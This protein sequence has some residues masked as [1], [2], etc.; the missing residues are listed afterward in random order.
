MK[1]VSSR[2]K[3]I[4]VVIIAAIITG[5]IAFDDENFQIAKN[6]DIYHTL[7][8]ELNLYYVDETDPGDLVKKSIDEMLQS[9]DPYTVYI[10]ESKMEDYR[11]MTTGQYGGIGALIRTS[12]DFVI[13]SEPYEGFPAFKAGLKAG[14]KIV[15]IDGKS[16][17]GK[18]SQDISKLLKGE[19][20][21]EINLSIERI[22]K[23]K[24]IELKVVREKIQ[25][26]SVPYSGMID[27]NIGYIRLSSFTEKCSKEVKKAFQLLKKDNDLKGL[28]FDLRGNPGGLLM[29]AVAISNLFVPKGTEVVSTK[30]KVKQWN[31][32]YKATDDA[33]D[34]EIPIAVLVNSGSASAS[35]IV[36]GVIQDLDRGV[37]MG[38]RT[39]GKGLVQ[40]TRDLSYNSKLKIT[41]AKYYIPSGRCIQALDYTHRNEDGSVGRIPDSLVSEFNTKGG[42][43]VYDGGGVMPDIKVE[44]Q[45]LSKISVSLY[46]KNLV[47]DYATQFQYANDSILPTG[48]FELNDEMYNDFVAFLIDKE[49]DYTLESEKILDD[50]ETAIKKDK[51]SDR[52]SGEIEDLRSKL[53]HDKDKDLQLFNSE[54]RDLLREEIISR[55]YY[56]RG[57]A[58][59]MIME[60]PLVDSALVVLKNKERYNSILEVEM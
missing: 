11:F 15:E 4:T 60:D 58:K 1:K 36:S 53:A 7:F 47:F 59:A 20:N 8:R 13:I 31:R 14:D 51:Y 39:Y 19:P 27:D 49:Y 46:R 34:T 52:I 43:S 42:R 54:I 17:K 38:T 3:I 29:E 10:P 32:T 50:L 41:T 33:L 48:K 21:T 56:Q 55:Y 57:R 24:T 45:S 35:E 6:L 22:S 16:V 9:L 28:V 23:E 44:P 26:S 2:I 30:G 5:F 37:V 40:T 18:N 12:G 25:I